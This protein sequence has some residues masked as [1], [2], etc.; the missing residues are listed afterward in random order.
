M[1]A[2]NLFQAYVKHTVKVRASTSIGAQ[3]VF[4]WVIPI[5]AAGLGFTLLIKAAVLAVTMGHG[6]PMKVLHANKEVPGIFAIHILAGTVALLIGPWQLSA[7]LRGMYPRLH[8]G[9]GRSYVGLALISAG[10]SLF[11]APRLDIFGTGYLRVLTALLWSTYTV[12]GV[13]AIRNLDITAHRRW[14]MRSYAF[15]FMGL[16]LLLYNW[17]GAKL[18]IELAYKYPAVAWLTF[19]TNVLFI[20]I[21]LWRSPRRTLARAHQHDGS[22][23]PVEDRSVIPARA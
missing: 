20:E 11:L 13:V 21:L 14:M 16:T 17:I 6:F 5:A 9:L 3:I 23:R 19:L 12:L 10:A 15:T 2:S 4:W 22:G 1:M 7:F 18:D 8:R